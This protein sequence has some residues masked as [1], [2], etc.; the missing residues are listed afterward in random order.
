MSSIFNSIRCLGN[1]VVDG[2]TTSVNTENLNVSDTYIYVNKNYTNASEKKT[3]LVANVLP[4]NVSVSVSGSFVPSSGI[5]NAQV[6]TTG[7][8]FSAGDIVQIT[9]T[10]GSLNDGIYEV[11]TNVGN[12]LVIRGVGSVL[13]TE[14][15]VQT[16]FVEGT[17]GTVTKVNA[18][19]IRACAGGSW[20]IGYGSTTPFTYKTLKTTDD[21]V[22]PV[23]YYS[24][25]AVHEL[26]TDGKRVNVVSDGFNVNLPP[27]PQDGTI[28][29][30]I[31][32]GT[33]SFNVNRSGSDYIEIITKF[34][35]SLPTKGDRVTLQYISPVWYIM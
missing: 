28:Y 29:T 25:M 6:L 11:S 15:F 21:L 8:V 9:G 30:I 26:K 35:V 4:T 18:S 17:G 3:G 20:E 19:V 33:L 32:T 14:P 34:S 1:L 31:N 5:N 16:D 23:K 24:N 7:S 2:T 22:E 10:S 12:L 27:A 13:Q